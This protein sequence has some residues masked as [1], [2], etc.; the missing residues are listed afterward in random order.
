MSWTQMFGAQI[1]TK[2]GMVNTA[3]A[4]QNKKRVAIYFSAHWCPP[5][6]QF[7]PILSQFYEDAKEVDADGL[8]IIFVSADSDLGQY[9]NYFG[10]MPFCS[11]EYGADVNDEI[12]SK[13]DVN[14]IPMLIV[15]DGKNGSVKDKEA[16]G[17]VMQAR[18]DVATCFS[19][20]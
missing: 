5:C 8:E 3:E 20:W 2:N 1:N 18:G 13:F 15:L 10:T 9:K 19:K 6:R 11:T 12:N 17:T 7:T 4:L 14:G 16:R